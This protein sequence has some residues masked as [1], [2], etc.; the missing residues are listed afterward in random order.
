MFKRIKRQ[1]AVLFF[2]TFTSFVYKESDYEGGKGK[3][4]VT[5]DGAVFLY[6]RHNCFFTVHARY[7]GHPVSQDGQYDVP[8]SGANGG[9]EQETTKAHACKTGRNGD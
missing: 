9:V 4:D 2:T 6:C 8:C 5:D 3:E 1:I 7:L